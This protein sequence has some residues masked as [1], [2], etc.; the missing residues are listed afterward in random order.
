V[1][2]NQ[3]GSGAE[4]RRDPRV[5]ERCRVSYR[6]LREGVAEARTTAARTV[7]LSASGVCLEGGAR[8]ERDQNLALEIFLPGIVKPVL[9]MGRVVW[10]DGSEGGYRSGIAFA[11][12]RDEDR[13]AL[14][15]LAEFLQSR[16]GS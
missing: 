13:K 12:M 16:L 6:I 3:G 8:L 10:C 7:N 4:R 15:A 2:A 9:A 11:W 14:G 5:A 1:D